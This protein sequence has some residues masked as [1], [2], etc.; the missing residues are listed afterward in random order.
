M[1]SILKVTEIQDPTNSNSAL[2]VDSSGRVSRG[3]VPAWFLTLG[4]SAESR[5][6][7]GEAAVQFAV[8]ADSGFNQTYIQGGASV[9][10]GVVTV[11]NTGLYYVNGNC[12]LDSLASGQWGRVGISINSHTIFDSA[13]TYQT[14]RLTPTMLVDVNGENF[15]GMDVSAVLKL[16]ANETVEIRASVYNDTSWNISLYDSHFTGYFIG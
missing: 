6:A 11:P 15:N 16:S 14:M 9:S 3:V 2:T 13:N 12:R 5:T 7:A 4:T 1:T 8:Q 10:N